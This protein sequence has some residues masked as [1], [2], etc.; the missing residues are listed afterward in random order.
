MGKI[1]L[2]REVIDAGPCTDAQPNFAELSELLKALGN[3]SP[4]PG[5]GPAGPD[6]IPGE[7]GKD[8]GT[9]E[10]VYINEEGDLV[11]VNED[12]DLVTISLSGGT[13]AEAEVKRFY[14][15]VQGKVAAEENGGDLSLFDVELVEY[16][17]VHVP[18]DTPEQID[19]RTV[20]PSLTVKNIPEL[21]TIADETLYARYN[22]WKGQWEAD[23]LN[24]VEAWLRAQRG[25]DLAT[26]QTLTHHLNDMEWSSG[27][28]IVVR[29]TIGHAALNGND[30]NPGLVAAA[31][32]AMKMT[33][34]GGSW[35]DDEVVTVH[36]LSRTGVAN[37]AVM[38]AT[39]VDG[40]Y[41]LSWPDMAGLSGHAN[42]DDLIVYTA[43]GSDAYQAAGAP[44]D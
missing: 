15:S 27:D 12:G 8:G 25:W 33:F 35:V 32:D 16:I 31:E 29:V 22:F 43:T 6:G 42:A 13:G 9:V 7:P 19:P 21:Q 5:P 28:S 4:D 1:V 41:V 3:P 23:S 2:G 39:R 26:K 14:L 44:C 24:N 20:L 36:N 34:T 37:N 40:I 11:Y 38:L 17:D 10:N 30:L 18:K